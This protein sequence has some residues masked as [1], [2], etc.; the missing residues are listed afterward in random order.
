MDANK[1]NSEV[2]TLQK[3]F[4]IYCDNNKHENIKINNVSLT[5]KNKTFTYDLNLCEQCYT[6]ISYSFERLKECK[7]DIKPKCRTC[8]SPC[9]EKPKWR[10]L[11]KIMKY[12]GMRLGLTKLKSKFKNIF[13]NKS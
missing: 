8:K 3:F 11:A 13:K 6:T 12:S 4:Q 9:Y 2:L 7:Y 10:E 1:F 5:Y